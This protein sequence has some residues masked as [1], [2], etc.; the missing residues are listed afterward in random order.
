LLQQKASPFF[1]ID[2]FPVTKREQNKRVSELCTSSSAMSS[3]LKRTRTAIAVFKAVV[4]RTLF[5]LHGFICIWRVT[6]IKGQPLYWLLTG[7]I[8]VMVLETVFTIKKKKGGEW[9]W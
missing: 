7:T 6:V 4:S 8:P 2:I 5:A 3:C 9:K 1:T